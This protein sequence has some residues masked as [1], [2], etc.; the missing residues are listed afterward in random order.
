MVEPSLLP[1]VTDR[2]EGLFLDGTRASLDKNGIACPD[3]RRIFQTL[4]YV[5]IGVQNSACQCGVLKSTRTI[6][7][8]RSNYPPG[9]PTLLCGCRQVLL[10]AIPEFVALIYGH[11]MMWWLFHQIHCLIK[12]G[13]VDSLHQTSGTIMWVPT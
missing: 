2:G 13:R 5:H 9:L 11:K 3:L 1:G 12:H 8:S 4:V 6:C 7:G 10:E